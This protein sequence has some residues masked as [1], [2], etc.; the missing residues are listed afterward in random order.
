VT[1]WLVPRNLM[2]NAP[3]RG[4]ITRY[5]LVTDQCQTLKGRPTV[6][7]V[8]D[9]NPA[10]EPNA[11]VIPFGKTVERH[12]DG[13]ATGE[14]PQK[15]REPQIHLLARVLGEIVYDIFPE[16]FKDAVEAGYAFWV[17]HPS[18]YLDTEFDTAEERDD[19]LAVMRA[20]AEI[21]G[22]NGEGYTIA[23]RV[24]EDPKMLVWRAQ[25]RRRHNKQ[26]D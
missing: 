7:E 12:P 1:W 15:Y 3:K 17:A 9:L 25:T 11:V 14:T 26:E 18:S 23:T 10:T 24:H 4:M 22:D 20:Y 21:A 2:K 13:L 6:G 5:A 19:S 16:A 8:K